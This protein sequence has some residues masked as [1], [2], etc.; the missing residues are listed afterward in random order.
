[1][2]WN[3]RVDNQAAVT[4]VAS[5]ILNDTTVLGVTGTIAPAAITL[6]HLG[7]IADDSTVLSGGNIG[8][9]TLTDC[10]G[11]AV[12]SSLDLS[13]NRMAAGVTGTSGL[14]FLLEQLETAIVT[15]ESG[16]VLTLDIS[17]NS[18][19]SLA[20]MIWILALC[21]DSCVIT[22]DAPATLTVSGTTSPSIDGEYAYEEAQG[23]WT[24]GA[25]HFLFAE[26]GYWVIDEAVPTA[27]AY[28][29]RDG[30]SPIGAYTNAGGAT[31]TVTVA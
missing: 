12:A 4:A 1:M 30:V 3:A 14:L 31:G 17:G 15:G 16:A 9:V 6:D 27:G 29:S 13:D 10:Y 21:E 28:F 11:V 24:A 20:S 18:V 5:K 26:A 7:G 2:T 25:G 23:L 22:C 19:P 8:T